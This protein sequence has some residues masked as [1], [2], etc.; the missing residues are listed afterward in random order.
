MI[1]PLPMN[2]MDPRT[3]IL[4]TAFTS[5]LMCLM[6]YSVKR[7]FPASIK[8]LGEWA[9]AFLV[10]FVGGVLV[11]GRGQLPDLLAISA[12]QLL[13]Q[14]G[15][16]LMYVGTQRFFGIKPRVGPW[17]AVLAGVLAVQVWFTYFAPDLHIRLVLST[18]LMTGLFGVHAVLVIRH[19]PA[20]FAARLTQTVLVGATAIQL[21]RLTFSFIQPLGAH[22]FDASPAHLVYLVGFPVSVLLL[23]VSFVLLASDRLHDDLEH[24]AMHDPLTGA[25]TRRHMGDAFAQELERCRRHGRSMA[26]LLMDLDHFK[27]INDAFGHPQGDRVLIRFVAIVNTL[28]R[29]GDM[30]GRFGGEEFVVLLPETSLE[31]GMHVAERIRTTVEQDGAKPSCTVSIGVTSSQGADTADT[32]IARADAAVYQ[33]KMTG[34]NRVVAQAAGALIAARSAVQD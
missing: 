19:G 24:L 5:S 8:G 14:A 10:F 2:S 6:L 23:S 1:D 15:T 20:G 9:T 33:A 21:M 25:L 11:A 3:I 16:Y 12:S 4:V 18:V 7:N 13:I 29:S 31:E 27:A 22:I 34:R 32:V 26:V 28:L 17:V 30:L